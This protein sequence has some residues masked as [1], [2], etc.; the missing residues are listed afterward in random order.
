MSAVTVLLLFLAGLDVGLHQGQIDYGIQKNLLRVHTELAPREFGIRIQGAFDGFF[1][2]STAKRTLVQDDTDPNVEEI[3]EFSVPSKSEE[4]VSNIDPLFGVDLDQYTK[5][6]SLYFVAARFA[7]QCHRV[8]LA[9]FYY[10]PLKIFTGIASSIWQL[11]DSPP[12]FCLVAIVIR[13]FIGKT[14]LGAKIPVVQGDEATKSKDVLSMAKSFAS[15]FITKSFPTAV[16]LYD[17]FSHVR[18]DMYV[19]LCGYLVGVA[20]MHS[21]D[22]GFLAGW[23]RQQVGSDNELGDVSDYSSPPDV[24]VK[25]HMGTDEL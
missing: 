18:S 25:D 20:Y 9:I 5:G 14:I 3:D 10:L 23:R 2:S 17:A 1:T 6:D 8:N 11:I 22:D 16:L 19:V 21:T 13:Q 24:M 4:V 7:V 15:N 12:L